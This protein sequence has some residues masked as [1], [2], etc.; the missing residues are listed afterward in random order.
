M[1]YR[2]SYPGSSW[3]G[4]GRGGTQ[5]LPPSSSS[6]APRGCSHFPALPPHSRGS[7]GAGVPPRI[8]GAGQFGGPWSNLGFLGHFGV[9]L[10][11]IWGPLG[12][13]RVPRGNFGSPEWFGVPWVW[14][15][16]GQSAV[17][18]GFLGSP[19]QFEA[20]WGNLGSPPR[21]KQLYQKWGSNP[22]GHTSIGS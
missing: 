6:P 19:G 8:P 18:Q 20:P 17:A 3:G 16:L 9:T 15:S 11:E 4:R 14:G 5:H 1:L 13:F 21:T 2:L 12:Q 10:G 7:L 22:R